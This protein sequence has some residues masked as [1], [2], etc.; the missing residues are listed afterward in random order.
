MQLDATKP[1]ITADE[2]HLLHVLSN[3]MDNAIKYSRKRLIF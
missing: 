3:L 2:E 1:E